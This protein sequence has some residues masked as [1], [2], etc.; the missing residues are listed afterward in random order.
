M[1][2]RIVAVTAL[3]AA[4]GGC[5]VGQK[6][7]Y[8]DAPMYLKPQS[9]TGSMALA[10]LDNRTEVIG[11]AKKA[12]WVGLSRGGYGNTFDV[13]TKSGLP[14]ANDMASAVTAALKSVGRAPQTVIVSPT[15][16][17]NG[18][19][20]AL[21]ASGADRLLLFTLDEWKTD[22]M[23][24]TGL[25]FDVSLTVFDRA[26]QSLATKRISGKEVSG[27]SIVSAEKDAQK[28]FGDKIAELLGSR[29][30]VAALG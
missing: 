5:A 25:D 24:R 21:V 20:A 28:W 19:R 14:L 27:S 3:L 13:T 26:G 18:A 2:V 16:G 7:S 4:L 9:A 23:M 1:I 12:S 10:V 22:T 29:E 15:D 11:G 17:V 30:I 6:F 8:A